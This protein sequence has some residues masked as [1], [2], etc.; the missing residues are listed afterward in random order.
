MD[1]Q[2]VKE[3]IMLGKD[4]ALTIVGLAVLIVWVFDIADLPFLA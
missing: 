4:I 1:I 2:K 3:W